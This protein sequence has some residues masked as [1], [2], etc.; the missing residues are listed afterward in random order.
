MERGRDNEILLDGSVV[1][2]GKLRGMACCI[3]IYFVG[4]EKKINT[5]LDFL[6]LTYLWTSNLRIQGEIGYI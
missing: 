6:I 5:V 4:G 3:M 1:D 2:R